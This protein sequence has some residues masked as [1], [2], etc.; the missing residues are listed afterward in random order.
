MLP[1]LGTS[2]ITLITLSSLIEFFL[3][4]PGCAK[5]ST[6]LFVTSVISCRQLLLTSKLILI[7][8]QFFLHNLNIVSKFNSQFFPFKVHRDHFLLQD[9]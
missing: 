8:S 5:S 1:Q 9:R 4:P 7:P 2:V 6:F 3:L